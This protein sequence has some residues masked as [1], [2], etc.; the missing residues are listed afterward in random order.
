[1]EYILATEED[2]SQ[3][4]RIVQNSIRTVYPKYYPQE[5]VDF[6]CKLH[7]E[8]N[9]SMDIKNGMVGIVKKNNVII[10]TG[11]YKDNHITRVYVDPLYQC[12]GYGSFIMQTLESAIGQ[13]FDTA[14]LDASTPASTLYEKR[15]YKTIKHE[16]LPVE[17]GVI[18]VYVIMEKLL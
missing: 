14:F 15:G 11:C 12:Q 3:I 8:E 16:K 4:T 7:C 9:I 18:L 5:V 1:M 2:T 13:K 6:F 10:G 17:N